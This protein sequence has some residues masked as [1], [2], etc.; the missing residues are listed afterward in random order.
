MYVYHI[1]LRFALVVVLGSYGSTLS[2]TLFNVFVNVF[3]VKLRS[4]NAGCFIRNM[5][6]GCFLYAEDI[7]ILS[8][9]IDLN[10]L[11]AMLETCM[12]V[13]KS[14]CLSFNLFKSHCITFG[15]RLTYVG[16][17][18]VWMGTR[19]ISW[20]DSVRYLGCSTLTRLNAALT[21]L[22]ILFTRTHIL[23]MKSFSC[24]RN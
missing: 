1:G 5:F 11:Q 19:S 22:V 21:V 8:P 23:F 15:K 10:G 16:P 14:L 24:L 7:I 2:P 3:K 6:C 9:S 20:V 13:S 12:A 18:Y 4:E 17:I